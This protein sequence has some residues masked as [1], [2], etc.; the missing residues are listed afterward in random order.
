V[1]VI[2]GRPLDLHSRKACAQENQRCYRL[3]KRCW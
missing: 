1:C 3:H 2:L